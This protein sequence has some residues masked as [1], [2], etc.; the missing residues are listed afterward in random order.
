MYNISKVQIEFVYLY[1]CITIKHKNRWLVCIEKFKIIYIE[2]ILL[3]V[4]ETLK[5]N[6]KLK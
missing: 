6:V 1:K 4:D 2:E 5:K 3:H